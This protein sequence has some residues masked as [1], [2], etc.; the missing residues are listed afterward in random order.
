MT[1]A[2]YVIR[3]KKCAP[4]K[5]FR[6]QRLKK[7]P[8]YACALHPLR[9]PIA[10]QIKRPRSPRRQLVEILALNLK[11]VQIGGR[12][13]LLRHARLGVQSFH[14]D[15]PLAVGI[16]QRVDDPRVDVAE[17]RRVRPNPQRQ[18]QHHH[19]RKSRVL[20]QHPHR[21]PNVLHQCSHVAPPVSQ[22]ANQIVVALLAAPP[23][24]APN[25]CCAVTC[26]A[27]FNISTPYPS[28]ND[29]FS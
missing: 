26:G 13:L 5:R 6:A 24:A 23:P 14:H 22:H 27:R 9:R 1:R 21:K 29:R 15:Q 16:G 11:V 20:Q 25:T 12:A 3:R 8:A 10:R 19:H 7:I 28:A 17:N 18:R 2:R 4:K